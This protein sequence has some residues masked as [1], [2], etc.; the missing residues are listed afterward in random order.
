MAWGGRRAIEAKAY[1]Q[2]VYGWTCWLCGH[3]IEEWDYS[4]DHVIERSKRPDLEWEPSNWRP[5]HGRRRP[6]YGCPGNYGRS[7][8]KR[9]RLPGAVTSRDW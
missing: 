3:P 4:L 9:P 6:E 8:R 2:R 5:A 7:G 1:C